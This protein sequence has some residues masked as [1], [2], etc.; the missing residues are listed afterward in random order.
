MAR[1]VAILA[2]RQCNLAA[3]ISLVAEETGHESTGICKRSP[4]VDGILPA[5]AAGCGGVGDGGLPSSSAQAGQPF[6]DGST[7]R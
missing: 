1:Y 5:R 4:W 7:R 6:E 3:S 2:T